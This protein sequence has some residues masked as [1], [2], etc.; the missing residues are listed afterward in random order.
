M[1]KVEG[2]RKRNSRTKRW[3][4][5]KEG[6]SLGSEKE[7]WI[8]QEKWHTRCTKVI[9]T[10]NGPQRYQFSPVSLSANFKV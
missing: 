9:E 5:G 4:V 6:H 10:W 8:G 2:K 3:R 7:V 1:G